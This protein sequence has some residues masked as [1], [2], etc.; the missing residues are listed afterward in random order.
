MSQRL[1]YRD[2]REGDVDLVLIE[3]GADGSLRIVVN[4]PPAPRRKARNRFLLAAS[5]AV[6][7]VLSGV[8]GARSQSMLI[9]SIGSFWFLGVIAA[10]AFGVLWLQ[11]ERTWVLEISAKEL[12]LERRG[13]FLAR[14]RCFA[15]GCVSDVQVA[16]SLGSGRG[17]ALVIRANDR[18]LAGRYFEYLDE[19]SIE[20]IATALRDELGVEGK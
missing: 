1:R 18:M 2:G 5:A 7:L 12:C 6:A 8:F 16:R 17:V 19:P 9:A 11:S 20:Q 14:R 4:Y 3:R 13:R 10:V 15:R